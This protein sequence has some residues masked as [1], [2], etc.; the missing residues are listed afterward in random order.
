MTVGLVLAAHRFKSVGSY[1]GAVL[2]L[3]GGYRARHRRRTRAMGARDQAGKPNG[4]GAE[5]RRP[6]A[7]MGNDGGRGQPAPARHR[8]HRH[9]LPA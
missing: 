8:P 2:P 1:A 9:L 5:R 7:Q 6:V 4:P 3:R